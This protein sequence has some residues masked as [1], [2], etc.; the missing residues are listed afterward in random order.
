MKERG[1]RIEQA[2]REDALE[3]EL[4]G[5]HRHRRAMDLRAGR[6]LARIEDSAHFAYRGCSNLGQFG[7]L[8]GYSARETRNLAAAVRAIALRPEMEERILEGAL[9]IDA[10]AALGKIFEDPSLIKDGEDWVAWAQN[11]SAR[12]LQREIRK[13]MKQSERGEPVSV[14]EAVMTASGREDFERSRTIASKKRGKPLTEGEAVEVLADH[15]LDSFDPLRQTPG[16]R[17]KGSTEFEEAVNGRGAP[18]AGGAASEVLDGRYVPAEVQRWVK[19]RQGGCCPVPGCDNGIWMEMAHL[20]AH[21]DGG[22]REIW[23]LIYLCLFHHDLYDRGLLKIEGTA[24]KPVFRD[25]D[26][27]VLGGGAR[28]AAMAR[29]AAGAKGRSASPRADTSGGRATD[30]VSERPPPPYESERSSGRSG[31]RYAA[32]AGRVRAPP[33]TG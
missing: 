15:Y 14:L 22:C 27:K 16:T 29:T 7:E 26:G 25:A 28:G 20:I 2:V 12:K 33:G 21:R 13:R 11:W 9:S 4:A 17:R 24:E 5:M 30:R 6:L 1:S 31:R 10:A 18:G 32:S 19:G 8:K 3:A 23:N